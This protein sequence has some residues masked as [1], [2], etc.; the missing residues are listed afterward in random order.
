MQTASLR[1][2][3]KSWARPWLEKKGYA[4][5]GFIVLRQSTWLLEK[6]HVQVFARTVRTWEYGALFPYGLVSD[7]HEFGV[8]VLHVEYGLILLE[9][10][11]LLGT[12][13]LARLWIHVLRQ[14]L[15]IWQSRVRCLGVACGVQ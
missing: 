12:Q 3:F 7:S 2:V 13:C 5:P 6:I 8:S 14:F 10:L 4:E 9:I 11:R 15:A 1:A